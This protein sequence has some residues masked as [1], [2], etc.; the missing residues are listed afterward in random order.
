MALRSVRV[1]AANYAQKI[2]QAFTLSAVLNNADKVLL[3]YLWR[4]PVISQA[5]LVQHP[6]INADAI[7]K[8]MRLKVLAMQIDR[9]TRVPLWVAND[10]LAC[11]AEI[12][13]LI[14]KT[15][16]LKNKTLITLATN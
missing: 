16:L 12:D 1:L 10:I 11:Y 2:N 13:A 14:L 9:T 4:C 3:A 8:F 6:T 15:K 5:V 7:N